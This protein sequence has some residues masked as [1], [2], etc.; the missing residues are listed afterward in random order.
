[1]DG[2]DDLIEHLDFLARNYPEYD[3]KYILRILLLE[4]GV[5][6]R[7]SGFDYIEEAVLLWYNESMRMVTK[8]IYP[9]IAR[10]HGIYVRPVQ[11]EG[12]IRVA[13]DRT[14]KH[15]DRVW[16]RFFPKPKKPTNAEFISRMAKVLEMW[17]D[18]REFLNRTERRGEEK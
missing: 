14:W 12:A 2:L 18:R 15:H 13:V 9:T 16:D 7:G 3:E 10:R 5:S 6:T 8:E 11:V 4:V 1:M 17:N